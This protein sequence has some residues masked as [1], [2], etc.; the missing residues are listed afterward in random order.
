MPTYIGLRVS[1]FGPLVTSALVRAGR[2]GSTV[3]PLSRNRRALPAASAAL[4]GRYH[5]ASQLPDRAC[6]T[7]AGE[8]VLRK[9]AGDGIRRRGYDGHIP[10]VPPAR[11]LLPRSLAGS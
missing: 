10:T 6:A 7:V 4:A 1:A 9:E 5:S 3:V 11:E 8:K 2:N